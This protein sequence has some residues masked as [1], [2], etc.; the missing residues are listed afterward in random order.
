MAV[1]THVSAEDAAV[2]LA[3]YDVGELRAL[4]GIAEGVENSNYLLETSQSQFILTL[5]ESRVDADDLPFFHDLLGHLH[6]AKLPVPRF[7]DDKEG[8]WLK[9][10]NGRHACLIEFLSGLSLSEPTPEQARSVGISLG[11]MHK[12]VADFK[13]VRANALGI[14]GW[15]SFLDSMDADQ[16]NQ[17]QAGLYN[18]LIAEIDYLE[19]YWPR[20]LPV[21]AIHSDLFPDNVLMLGNDVTGLIDFYFACTDITG[22]DLAVTHSAWCFD[23]ENNHFREDVSDALFQGYQESFGM[24]GALQTAFPIL[25][26][27]SCLRF[28]LTRTFDWINTPAGALVT[29]KDPLVFLERL[30]HYSFDANIARLFGA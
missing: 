1:Y 16:T 13:P 18:R 29:R 3:D 9:K 8:R 4:K 25:A 26:R 5:Y 17:I 28:L 10:I 15:R 27:G 30:D 23:A 21:S 11:Q 20:H 12:A 14:N 24:D 19:A 2:F 22:Y 6:K 7:I